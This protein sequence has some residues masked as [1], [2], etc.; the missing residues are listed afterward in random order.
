M[1]RILSATYATE[2]LLSFY[3]RGNR[4]YNNN[5]NT[6]TIDNNNQVSIVADTEN[7]DNH[8]ANK[9]EVHKSYY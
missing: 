8:H 3:R 9:N 4:E 6:V 7:S 2:H 1:E 5:S